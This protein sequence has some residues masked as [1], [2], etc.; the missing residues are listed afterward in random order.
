MSANSQEY[1]EHVLEKLESMEALASGR[2]FGGTGISC[3]S[4]QFGMLM[5]NTLYFVVDEK[6]RPKYE[7]AGS[8]CFSYQTSKRKVFVHKYYEVP[9]EV[10]DDGKRFL[11]CARESIRA[12]EKLNKKRT[13]K[14]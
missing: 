2:F 5:G 9:A 10:F 12:A 6:T 14:K 7:A 1:V 13:K 8:S 11:E 3:R 4:V